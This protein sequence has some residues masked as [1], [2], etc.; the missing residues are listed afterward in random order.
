MLGD[1][2]YLFANPVAV[3]HAAALH[4]L[5]VLFIVM[6]NSMWGA[7]NVFTRAMY[8]DGAAA[9]AN[10]QVF[11]HLDKLP[12]FED[13]ARAAGGYGA[14]VER[15]EELPAAIA[16]AGRDARREAARAVER[17]LPA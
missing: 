17:D 7:V 11:T 8:P 9:R 3:H 14:R 4:E 15:P 1:G 10:K 13:V 2:A 16:G 6:N 12:S 5:P